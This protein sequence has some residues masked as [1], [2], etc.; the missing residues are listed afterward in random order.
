MKLEKEDKYVP[1]S[2]HGGSKEVN[3]IVKDSIKK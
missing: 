3:T 2:I 1:E